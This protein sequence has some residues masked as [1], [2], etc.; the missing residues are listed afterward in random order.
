MIWSWCNSKLGSWL[1]FYLKLLTDLF[2]FFKFFFLLFS[3]YRRKNWY[4]RYFFLPPVKSWSFL[5]NWS[6]CHQKWTSSYA[7]KIFVFL[8]C[9]EFLMRRFLCSNRWSQPS[10]KWW[11]LLEEWISV[12]NIVEWFKIDEWKGF[13]YFFG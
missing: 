9:N 7:K 6:S 8:G 2:R 13:G 12:A 1:I 11:I 4:K 10:Y 3:K 5:F